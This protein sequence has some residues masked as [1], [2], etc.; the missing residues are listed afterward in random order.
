[1]TEKISIHHFT[2]TAGAYDA[3]MSRDDLETG[4]ILVIPSEKV[5]GLADAWPVA[6]TENAGQLH[7]VR[8]DLTLEGYGFSPL[9]VVAAQ[10]IARDLG[11]PL[12]ITGENND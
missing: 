7:H 10:G 2:S 5:V 4:A 9:R 8:D 1:M 6:V 12:H 11:Y 3:A